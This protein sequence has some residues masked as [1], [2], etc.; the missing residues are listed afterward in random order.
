MKLN[1]I[2]LLIFTC[3]NAFSQARSDSIAKE[4]VDGQIYKAVYDSSR[5]LSIYGSKAKRVFFLNR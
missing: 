1:L 2:I 5:N 3:T 4:E